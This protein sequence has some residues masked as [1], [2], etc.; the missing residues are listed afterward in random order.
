MIHSRKVYLYPRVGV[1]LLFIFMG[2]YGLI[3]HEFWRDEVRAL[4]IAIQADS[5]FDLPRLLKNEGHPILWYALL[6]VFYHLTGSTS[7][8]PILSFVF[9]SGTMYLLLFKSPFPILISVCIGFGYWG[10]YSNGI[11][12]RN[13]GIGA[14]LLVLFTHIRIA[15]PKKIVLQAFLLVLAIQT[16]MYM[17]IM[18]AFMAIIAF[19]EFSNKQYRKKHI[20]V[21]SFISASLIFAFYTT[22]PDSQSTVVN[23][24]DINTSKIF[25]LWDVGYGFNGFIYNWFPYKH[26]F[27]TWILGLSLLPFLKAKK[28]LFVLVFSMVF[29]TFFSL[30]IRDNYLHHQGMWLY[31]LISLLWFNYK[32]ILDVLK[33]KTYF[34]YLYGIGCLAILF[35]LIN[36][37]HRG[38]KMYFDDI[39]QSK[40]DSK[41]FATWL[42]NNSSDSEVWI[43]EPDYIMEPVMY[44]WQHPFYLVREN[45]FNTY[46]HF[47]K[48]NDSLLNLSRILDVSDSF[49]SS[50]KS[51]L[52]ILEHKVNPN[53]SFYTYSMKR[54]NID[55]SAIK[56]LSK[57]YTLL[58]S[59]ID[60]YYTDEHYFVYR[61]KSLNTE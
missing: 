58:D 56:K 44:Y 17:A 18:S 22:L 21:L 30:C 36:S 49:H 32:Q 26:G 37:F 55:S 6:N 41:N 24:I 19:T 11:N 61:R 47:T 60:N 54:F 46:V 33:S 40:S 42:H 27:L 38:M 51:T 43:T 25:K 4:S 34:R 50:G 48:A 59:F 7:V 13:Y 20:L 39:S 31:F 15:H 16:N 53:D 8:L 2:V 52:I 28:T 9:A 35:I 3:F 1:F 5:I 23:T 12:C 57:N 14:F 10:L 45:R 29:M